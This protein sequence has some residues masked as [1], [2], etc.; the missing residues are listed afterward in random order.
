M[1]NNCTGNC[2]SI[3][4][5]TLIELLIVIAIIAILAGMLLPALNSA[6]EKG[7]DASCKS[8]LKQLHLA[9]AL[10][11]QDFQEWCIARIYSK[12]LIPGRTLSVPWYGALQEFKYLTNGKNC[13]CPTNKANVQGQYPDDG[14]HECFSTYGLS[15]GTFGQKG[16]T[17]EV[18]RPIKTMELAREKG[19]NETVMFSDTANVI[20]GNTPRTSF[21]GSTSYPGSMVN[22]VNDGS[23]YPFR[24]PADFKPYGVYLLHG[25][26][27]A[28]VVSFSGS[29][30]MFRGYGQ[31]VRF[32]PIYRPN[33]RS[34]DTYPISGIF[35]GLNN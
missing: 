8:N 17:G 5:F 1:K 18:G 21:A 14:S 20:S 13:R 19:G 27:Q 16:F 11:S 35:N 2:G 25:G 7:R 33:R 34:D 22:N 15:V 6:R 10:Y 23:T 3:C 30:G 31:E 9:A 32:I 26:G 29:V 12:N 4:F 28:N 24:G